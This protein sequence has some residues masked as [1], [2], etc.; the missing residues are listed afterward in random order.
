MIFIQIHKKTP[1]KISKLLSMN[2]AGW[3]LIKLYNINN[4]LI[5]SKGKKEIE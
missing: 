4:I 5:L 2:C 1:K 3:N